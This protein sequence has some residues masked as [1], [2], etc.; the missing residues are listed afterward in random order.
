MP[1]EVTS[2]A[3]VPYKFNGALIYSD[4]DHP[5]MY[6]AP[7]NM[8]L[9]R[10]GIAIRIN[11]VTAF[12]AGYARYAVPWV[13]IHPETW[14][15]PKNGFSQE[16]SM[17]T[18][19]Q[20]VPRTLLSDPFPSTNPLQL[21][22]GNGLG[23]Y[24]DLGNSVTYWDGNILKTPINDRFNFTI[25]RQTVQ[26]IF[27]EATFFMMFG[28]NVQDGSMWGGSN[29][30]NVNQ[31]DPNLSYQYKGRV[32]ESVKNPFYNLL[33]TNKM[34]GSL[35]R[36]ETVSVSQLLRPY[37]QY[38][39]LN[40]HGWP[41]FTDHYYAL[42]M[43]AERP[44]AAGLTFL[45]AYNYGRETHSQYFNDPDYYANRPT[46]WDRARPRHNLRVA[47]T[48]ELPFGRGRHYLNSIPR[49]L[50]YL[51]GGWA[52]SHLLMWRSGDL[53][54]FGDAQVSGNPTQNVPSGL[55]FNPAVFATLPAYTPRT[56][57][58]YYDGLR[59]PGFWQL[60][61]TLVKYFRV[62]ER[63]RF[64]LRMEFY[65]MPNAF[66]PSNPDMGVGSGTMGRSTWVAGGNY[67]REIQ[68]TG[69]IHF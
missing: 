15:I 20:G 1:P 23:R 47:G 34:P 63:V 12:R 17:L 32:D 26:R 50:D 9:P 69:R 46:M 59:G 25:Q 13:T 6:D 31:M 24:T 5:R 38:G 60:D 39:D 54:W 68:Y 52:T 29:T 41:G 16:T 58:F 45:V 30:Y 19:L 21:P 57:P 35:G 66:M 27:T 2:I 55:Y 62:T 42:Q 11:D 22:T 37:P 28:H 44:M 4:N 14:D 53:L 64:E 51:I 3:K 18:P 49:S 33:P 8:F 65:N 40:V 48:W 43:K 7:W 61:S 67:G 36:Q 10:A 56:N